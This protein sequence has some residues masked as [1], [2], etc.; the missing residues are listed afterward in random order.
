[1]SKPQKRTLPYRLVGRYAWTLWLLSHEKGPWSAK[2]RA[3]RERARQRRGECDRGGVSRGSRAGVRATGGVTSSRLRATRSHDMSLEVLL[4][5]HHLHMLALV[6]AWLRLCDN[7]ILSRRRAARLHR[8]Q[9]GQAVSPFVSLWHPMQRTQSWRAINMS[10]HHFLA[11]HDPS[12]SAQ[13]HRER[14]GNGSAIERRS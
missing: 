12:V 2:Y 11:R 9:A 8:I 7:E 6:L 10:Y 5:G 4:R 14:K 1:M 3:V 13:M